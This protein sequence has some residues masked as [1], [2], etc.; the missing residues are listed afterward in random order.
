MNVDEREMVLT[1]KREGVEEDRRVGIDI[2][3][4]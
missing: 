1:R 4:K 2:A 3:Y